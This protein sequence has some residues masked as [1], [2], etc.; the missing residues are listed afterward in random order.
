[1][2]SRWTAVPLLMLLPLVWRAGLALVQLATKDARLSRVSAP[3]VSLALWLLAIHAS[4]LATHS[5]YVAL[6][7]GTVGVAAFGL[8][9]FRRTLP[10][11]RS[12]E[13]ATKW[14]WLGALVAA[15]AL[16][17]PVL[18]SKH[19]EC[20]IV[21]HVSI[22]TEMENGIYPPR[23]L[24][25]PNYELRYHYA[26]DLAVAAVSSVFA[27]LPIPLTVHA[28][29]VALFGYSF[30]L[31]WLLGERLTGRR[32]AGP[33]TAAC[34]MFAGGGPIFFGRAGN[35]TAFWDSVRIR[36]GTWITPPMIS[37]FLQHPWSLGIP[38]FAI[39]LL[40]WVRVSPGLPSRWGWLLLGTLAVA[41]SLAQTTLFVCIVPCLVALGALEGHRPSAHRFARY[42]AWAVAVVLAARLL[43]GFLAPT[44][45]PAEGRI[46]L[47]PFWGETTPRE[48][49][50][51]HLEG[52]GALLPLGVAGF[53]FL[54]QQRLLLGLLAAGGLLVR[55][56]FKYWPGWNIVKFSVV[57]ELALAILAAA[58]LSTAISRRRWWPLGIAGLVACTFVSLAFSWKLTV[59]SPGRSCLA[60]VASPADE[61]AIRFLRERVAAGEAVFRSENPDAYAELGGLPQQSWD[62]GVKSFG[63]S[64]SL[65]AQRQHLIDHP[66]DLDELE[67]QGFRWLVLAARDAVALD[68]ARR[69]TRDGRAELAAEFPPLAVY[70]LQ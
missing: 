31:Y 9:S 64:D 54:R 48:F 45:E 10:V 47:H 2:P 63:F 34:V 53:F 56:L 46:G 52:F 17:G 60:R 33:V 51:W 30:A 62:W 38:L 5:F 28:L 36:G 50:L 69:W 11:E 58:V 70:R 7:L 13:R 61:D 24:T 12:A 40:V 25:F 67:K 1:M 37:N 26:V 35:G 57:S 65:Y 29:A 16:V 43:H 39:V 22:P 6:Y 42:A 68:A 44:P 21:G 20:L 32:A 27:R 4:G 18:W 19:D 23:H 15:C 14:M 49:L 59:D 41:L 55:D 3:G 66:D 8:W